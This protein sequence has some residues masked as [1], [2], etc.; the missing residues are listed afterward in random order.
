MTSLT[1]DKLLAQTPTSK[2]NNKVQ[3]PTEKKIVTI[4]EAVADS[5]NRY[6]YRQQYILQEAQRVLGRYQPDKLVSR[7]LYDHDFSLI[8][9]IPDESIKKLFGNPK[10]R[11]WL[12]EALASNL[13]NDRFSPKKYSEREI[14]D[15]LS[16]PKSRRYLEGYVREKMRQYIINIIK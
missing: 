11:S 13:S 16:E 15:M 9:K 12:I 6:G 10:Y 3:N 4:E 1:A 14:N 8:R 5:E 2:G 7:F